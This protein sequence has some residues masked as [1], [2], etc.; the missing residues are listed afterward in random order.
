[1]AVVKRAKA[2]S[3]RA[4]TRAGLPAI[5]RRCEALIEGRLTAEPRAAGDWSIRTPTGCACALCDD[6]RGFLAAPTETRLE[7]KL[8]KDGRKHIHAMLDTRELPVSHQTRR[9]G[10]PFTLVLEKQRALFAREARERRA[11]EADLAWLK[12]ALSV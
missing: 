12:E 8:A 2:R 6:L 11:L 1:M 3:A 7:W 4:D 5:R 10:R 9:V